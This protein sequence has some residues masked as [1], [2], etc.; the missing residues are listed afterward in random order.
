MSKLIDI[1]Q[2]LTFK[3]YAKKYGVCER[4]VYRHRHNKDINYINID[5]KYFIKDE[6]SSILETNNSGRILNNVKNLTDNSEKLRLSVKNLTS[7][8]NDNV[9]KLTVNNENPSLFTENE[10]SKNVKKLT[11][12][13]S[14]NVKNLTLKERLDV[15]LSIP[16]LDRT[17]KEHQEIINI[18]KNL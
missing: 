13:D 15:L 10:D 12:S 8:K 5:G 1:K 3:N 7:K 11:V 9:K 18:E 2:Y 14:E 4:K 6:R 16:E 17:I